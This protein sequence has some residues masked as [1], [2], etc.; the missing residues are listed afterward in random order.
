MPENN[1]SRLTNNDLESIRRG[2]ETSKN[3]VFDEYY[4]ILKQYPEAKGI[5]KFKL[6]VYASGLVKS[7]RLIETDFNMP[8]L[9]GRLLSIVK[10]IKFSPLTKQTR[11]EYSF[12]FLPN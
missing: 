4:S 11:V 7:I 3:K 12:N 10:K 6:E 5:I 1:L 2:M 9:E 8:E